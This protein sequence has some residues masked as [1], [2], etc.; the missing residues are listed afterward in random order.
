[1][2]LICISQGAGAFVCG[3]EMALMASIEGRRGE[4]R[5]KPPFPAVAGLWNKPS[6]VNN[7]KSYAISPQVILHG[8]EWFSRIGT[9]KSPGTAI[10]ALTGKINNAGLIEVRWDPLGEIIFDVAA[11]FWAST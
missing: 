10:F 9:P 3:E 2:R 1:L 11:A 6:N 7:V 8:A 4:P 5:P